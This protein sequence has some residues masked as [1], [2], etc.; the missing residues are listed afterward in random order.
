MCNFVSLTVTV[1]LISVWFFL[2]GG[3]S[4]RCRLIPV[5]VL[6][7]FILL[8]FA[9]GGCLITESQKAEVC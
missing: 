4:E 1:G 5:V 6:C 3:S 8:C 7:V 9:V 2:A